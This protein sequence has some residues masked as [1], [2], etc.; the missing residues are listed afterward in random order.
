M[1]TALWRRWWFWARVS[2]RVRP[3]LRKRRP[4]PLQLES[5]E[6]RTLLSGTPQLLADIN[7]GSASSNPND[8]V[9]IGTEVY[10]VANDG[11]HG[12]QV[13]KSDGSPG[14]T[15][16]LTDI[17]PGT[18]GASPNNLTNVNDELFFVAND[19]T[20]G[21]Q[22]WKS[23]GT[24]GGTTLVSDINPS[25]GGSGS[26][27]LTNVN[28][29]LFFEANDGTNGYQLYKSDGTTTGTVVV[30]STFLDPHNLTDVN[31]EL[32]FSASDAN[33]TE[34][35]KSDGTATG[36]VSLTGNVNPS[37][38][39]NVK[40]TLFFGEPIVN[41]GLYKSDGTPAGTVRVSSVSV[42][43]PITNVNGE[44]YF[45]GNDGINGTQLWK[46]DGTTTGTTMLAD[47]NPG[48]TTS[49]YDKGT[50]GTFTRNVTSISSYPSNITNVNG[51]LY[52]SANDGTDGTQLWKSD[53]TT[54][55]TTLVQDINPGSSTVSFTNYYYNGTETGSATVPN[56]SYPSNLTNLNGTLLFAANDGVHGNELWAVP[57][58]PSLAVSAV[59]TN[60]TAGQS[61]TFTII[62]LKADGTP[63]T[64]LNGA[65]TISTSDAKAIYPTSVTLTNGTAQ[66]SVTFKT[67]GPQSV[68]A[69]DVQTP[70]VNGV[71]TNLNVQAAAAS[72]FKLSG[73]PSTQTVATPGTFSVIAYDQYG[74]VATDY[75]GTIHFTSSDPKAVLPANATLSHGVGQFSATLNTVATGQSI[76]STDTQNAALT[77]T[78]SNIA[79]IPSASISGPSAGYPGQTLTYTL[80]AGA[81]PAGTVFTVAWGDGTSTQTTAATVSHSYTNSNNYSISVPASANGLTSNPSTQAVDIVPLSVAVEA[82]PAQA[83]KEMLVISAASGG[84]VSLAGNS[85]GVSLTYGGIALGNV[86]P[87]N[88]ETFALVEVFGGGYGDVID[89]SNLSVS[90]VLVGNG[91]GSN[92]L[93]GGSGRNLLIAGTGSGTLYAGSAGDI[94]IGGYTSYDSGTLS[95]QT[96]LASIMAEWD[97]TDSYST[98]IKKLSGKG[99]S[100]GSYDL[101]SSTVFDSGVTDYLYGYSQATVASLDWFFAHHGRT[102]SDPVYNQVSGEVVTK[103]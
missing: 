8:M 59:S 88:N 78:E 15:T 4:R 98:R 77:A 54:L 74:N 5:L 9:V 49:W 23:D 86:L 99:G 64:T 93:Y 76:T 28:G 56:S 50:Y 44:L 72:S 82:D 79:V 21:S 73:F 12:S 71:D 43:G 47:I 7:P 91:S 69:T 39:T 22:V 83:G 30:P 2:E 10:F 87:T 65:V 24:S 97:S 40:G 70:T 102:N 68:T 95:N 46:S 3:V 11:T 42:E 14:G 19:V 81:D 62:A 1:K 80:G 34:L 100:G 96:A 36:T 45:A 41:G 58:G 25:N 51:T 16:M 85:S 55:G 35:W 26:R 6:D 53:G 31:G 48:T 60:P 84:D 103:I 57:T 38:L 92:L 33:H 61:D 89:A 101:N 94:L 29:E 20:H 67:A 17:N 63:D 90:S 37:D 75:S 66:F 32:F 52:F 18:V 27:Y 13:W